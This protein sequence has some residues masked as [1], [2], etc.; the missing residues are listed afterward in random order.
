VARNWYNHLSQGIL[1]AGF[2]QSKIDPCLFCHSDCFIVLYTDDTLI[3]A[4]DDATI[5]AVIKTLS[6]NFQLEDKGLV[7]DFLGIQL[8]HDASSQ[9]IQMTQPGLIKSMIWD[10]GLSDLSNTKTT[11][12]DSILHKDTSNSPRDD[13]WNYR[14]VIGKLS[15]LAQNTRPDI[16]FAVH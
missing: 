7:S 4:K 15:N 12:S 8:I 6:E 9:C 2:T 10:V 13:T 11:P 16:S 14:S 1:S 5:D 3:F